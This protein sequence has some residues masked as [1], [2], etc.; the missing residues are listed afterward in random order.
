MG[1]VFVKEKGVRKETVEGIVPISSTVRNENGLGEGG[2]RQGVAY[3]GE[4]KKEAY[5]KGHSG[6]G[7]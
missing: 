1:G 2:T 4:G 3:K 5:V 6:T 7:V